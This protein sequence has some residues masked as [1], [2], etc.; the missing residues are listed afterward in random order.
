[1]LDFTAA[2]TQP[3][4]FIVTREYRR[5]AEFCDACRDAR[6]IGLCYGRPGVGKTV[7]A[8]HYAHW[9]QLESLLGGP[10]PYRH[11]PVPPSDSGPWQT[12]LY[13]PGVSN[14]PRCVEQAV[15]NLWGTVQGL[16]ARATWYGDPAGPALRHPP[17]LL[18]VDEADRLKTA[19]LEQLRDIYD[20]RPLGMVLIGMPGLQKRLARYAQLYSRVGFVHQFQPLSG[21]ELQGV[22]EH[23]WVQLGLDMADHAHVDTAVIN[24]IA[25]VTG[26]NFRL[27]QRLFAQIERII[28]TN[29]LPAVT[30]EV[31]T[32]ARERLVEG[33]G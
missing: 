1:L 20:R 11:T 21:Q 22:I 31:V 23:Q 25:R 8:R 30:T 29:N 14:T 27:V 12:V 26:G 19:S 10:P 2:A 4:D 33:A 18:V 9:T 3:A 17:D 5:F 32:L 15:G 16:S 6:Y 7:S 24:A 28:A 13:T